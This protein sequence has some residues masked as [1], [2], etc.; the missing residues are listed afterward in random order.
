V[1]GSNISEAEHRGI[2]AVIAPA[3]RSDEMANDDTAS[4][5]GRARVAM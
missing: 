2:G 1:T 3:K 5:T 4:N